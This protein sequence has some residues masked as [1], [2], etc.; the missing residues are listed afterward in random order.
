MTRN[1]HERLVAAPIEWVGPLLDRLGGPND[2][3]WPSPAW[4]PMV[5]DRPM[6]VGAAG[7]HGSIRYRVTVHQP[8][9]QVEVEFAPGQGLDGWFRITA[10]PSGLTHTL[11]RAVAE[12]QLS[13]VM[14]LAWPLAVRWAH[15]AVVEE[16]LDNAERMVGNEP[17]R[18]PRRSLGV[19]L[20]RLSESPRARAA[21]IPVASLLAGTLPGVDWADAQSLEVLPGMPQDPQ[22]WAEAIFRD[23]PRSPTVAAGGWHLVTGIHRSGAGAAKTLAHSDDE[24]LLGARGRHLDLRA[25]V[26]RE[27]D[28]VVLTTTVQRRNPRG[29]ARVALVRRLHPVLV[30]AMLNRAARRLSAS[31]VKHPADL[32]LPGPAR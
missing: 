11:V 7:G 32:P 12:A 26:R 23:W 27:S 16:L 6:G 10:E 14:V 29:R 15:D 28:R 22:T 4:Q 2:M 8:G 17:Q 1:A 19:G 9:R 21:A 30:R 18:S 3:L 5:L 24:V 31:A 13:G 25:S 20:L